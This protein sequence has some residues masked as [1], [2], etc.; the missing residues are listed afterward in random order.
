[1]KKQL[2]YN[3]IYKITNFINKCYIGFHTTDKLVEDNELWTRKYGI[4][5]A[6]IIYND[7]CIKCKEKIPWNKNKKCEQL[8]GKNNGNYNGIWYGLNPAIYQK[9]K[10]LEEIYG[11]EKSNKIKQKR[12][13]TNSNKIECIYYNKLS[14]KANFK[15]WHGEN[16]K[17]KI[18]Y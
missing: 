2:K 18:I 10:S 8:A 11:I 1:M 9:G 3:Y 6:N 7:Y 17:Q 12:K 4:I 14:N 16:C 5:R 15:R 13:L